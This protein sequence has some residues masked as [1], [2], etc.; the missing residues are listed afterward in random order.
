M[1][2]VRTNFT[3]RRK[4]FANDQINFIVIVLEVNEHGHH[5]LKLE[6]RAESSRLDVSHSFYDTN[7]A[8]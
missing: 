2:K 8:F 3:I 7:L 5:R 6:H 1:K 4:I